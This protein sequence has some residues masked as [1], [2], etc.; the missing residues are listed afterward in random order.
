M[1]ALEFDHQFTQ[2][3]LGFRL[4]LN[5]AA[6]CM[7]LSSDALA[8]ALQASRKSTLRL[9]GSTVRLERCMEARGE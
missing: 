8:R 2:R 7:N 4:A 5:R 3:L 9:Q 1:N 6:Q